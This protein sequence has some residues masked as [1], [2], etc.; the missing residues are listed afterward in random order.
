MPVSDKQ[1]SPGAIIRELRQT[2]GLTQEEFAAKI[3]VSQ[4]LIAGLENHQHKPSYKTLQGI[5]KAFKIDPKILFPEN[6]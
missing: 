1:K 4:E 2:F 3:G 6:A 5:I